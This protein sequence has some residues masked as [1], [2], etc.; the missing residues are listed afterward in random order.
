MHVKYYTAIVLSPVR[1]VLFS[2]Y[3]IKRICE[4]KISKLFNINNLCGLL[5]KFK[6]VFFILRC[7]NELDEVKDK[8]ALL[9]GLAEVCGLRAISY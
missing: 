8:I 5:E 6:K 1:K 7:L 2:N 3:G 4:I 9:Q